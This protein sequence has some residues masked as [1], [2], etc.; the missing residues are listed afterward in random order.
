MK[1]KV[2]LKGKKF[3]WI[4]DYAKDGRRW[5]AVAR[6]NKVVAR[7]CQPFSR[8]KDCA[9]IM[10]DLSTDAL[11][12]SVVSQ[13]KHR[14]LLAKKDERIAYLLRRIDEKNEHVRNLQNACSVH[15]QQKRSLTA[16]LRKFK[17]YLEAAFYAGIL[18]VIIAVGVVLFN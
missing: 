12:G 11:D 16:K 8:S 4:I 2:H 15:V 5:K 18:V 14:Q 1:R 13:E 7:G 10:D 6:N 17:Q 9:D 3:D